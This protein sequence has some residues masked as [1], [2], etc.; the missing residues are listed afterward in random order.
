MGKMAEAKA[1]GGGMREAMPSVT[2]FIDSMRAASAEV[3]GDGGA[4]ID[5]A[6]RHGLAN[7]AKA[8]GYGTGF[9]AVENKFVTGD[10]IWTD[11]RTVVVGFPVCE[12][13]RGSPCEAPLSSQVKKE[14][15]YKGRK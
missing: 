11:P 4:S 3:L 14:S 10:A 8:T 5:K 1:K 9:W 2:A 6:I 15:T 12:F 13:P 7:G